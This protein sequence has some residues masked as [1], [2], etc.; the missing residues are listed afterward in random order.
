MMQNIKRNKFPNVLIKI[1]IF[2]LT[3]LFSIVVSAKTF[4]ICD[5]ITDS[6]IIS[7]KI[8]LDLDLDEGQLTLLKVWTDNP[9]NNQG[10]KFFNK[11]DRIIDKIIFETEDHIFFQN[12]KELD[13]IDGIF[14]IKNI[15]RGTYL[16]YKCRSFTKEEW[17]VTD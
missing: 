7:G 16:A 8:Y 15:D 6:D 9:H 4:L 2:F 3:F 10:F 5:N 13:K 11:K 17:T 1:I 12:N 14:T